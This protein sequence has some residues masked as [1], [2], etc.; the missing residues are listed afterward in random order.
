MSKTL[1]KV[2]TLFAIG[3]LIIALWASKKEHKDL[4]VLPTI[5]VTASSNISSGISSTS[6]VSKAIAVEELVVEAD[7]IV[8]ARVIEPPTTRIVQYELPV[9]DEQNNIVGTATSQMLFSDTVFEV[10]EI[11][12]GKPSYKI[13]VMQT[14][15]FD[16]SI[17]SDVEEIADDPLYKLGEEYI[18]FLVDISGDHIHAPDRELYRVVNPFGRYR[19]V[20][21]KVVSYGQSDRSIALPTDIADLESQITQSVQERNK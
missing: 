20:N 4:N 2:S 7:I 14:G 19:I 9:W 13:T 5:S 16:P 21:E 8:R 15:G 10:L 17:S 12:L 18:L 6:W 11:Y 1:R 3:I